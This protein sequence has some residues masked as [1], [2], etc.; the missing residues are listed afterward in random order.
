MWQIVWVDADDCI[1]S[2]RVYCK[3]LDEARKI[4]EEIASQYGWKIKKVVETK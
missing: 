1:F 4:A 3:N 2:S